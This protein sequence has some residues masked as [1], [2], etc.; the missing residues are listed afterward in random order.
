MIKNFFKIALR[1][2]WRNK[3]NTFVNILG[4]SVGIASCILISLHVMDEYSYDKFF[5]NSD[6][7]Y[8]VALNRIY[9]ENTISYA[10]IPHSYGPTIKEDFP[11]VEAQMRI[12]RFNNEL[13]FRYEENVFKENNFCFADSTFFDFFSIKL[14]IGDP[15]TVLADPTSIVMTES[16]AKRYFGSDDPLGKMITTPFGEIKVSGVCED[17]PENSHMD[18]DFLG[19]LFVNQFIRAVNYVSFSTHTYIK[20]AAGT[21]PTTVQ[22]KLPDLVKRY[23][24][25]QIES[26]MGV[27]FEEYTKA[28]N[29]YDYFLQPLTS[30]HLH[31]NLEA[32]MNP[33]GDYRYVIIFISIAIFILVLACINFINLSTAQAAE[34]AKEVGIRKVVGSNKKFLVRQFLFESIFVSFFSLW[35][36]LIL[37][38]LSL[39]I[40]NNLAQKSL[41]IDYFGNPY[42]LPSLFCVS[43]FVGI[44]AG[45]YP[46]FFLSSYKPVE[47]LKG[48]FGSS[49]RGRI[50]RYSLVIFQFTISIGLIAFTL[51]VNSQ[52]RYIMNKNL[53]FDKEKVVVVDRIFSLRENMQI[54]IDEVK[55]MPEVKNVSLSGSE[56]QGGFYF[57]VMLQKDAN[58]EILTTRG[59]IVDDFFVKTMGL[60]IADGRDFSDQF[61][62]SLKVLVNEAFVK[63]FDFKEPVGAR[64]RFRF[65]NED[66]FDEYTIVGVVKNYHYN[67]LH[68]P[69]QSFIMFNNEER[70]GAAGQLNVKL[71]KGNITS[72]I[73][74]IENKWNEFSNESLF[75]YYFLDEHLGQMYTMEKTSMR[76]FSIFSLLAII[77]AC[78]G[79]LGLASY[80]AIQRTKE[81]GIR[82]A[83]GA[84]VSNIILLL[85]YDFTKW[86]VFANIIAWPLAYLLMNNWLKNFAYRT[87]IGIWI[88]IVSGGLSI[89]IA[90]V[91]IIFMAYKAASRNP[92]NSLRYE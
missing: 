83:M 32:E 23:A 7:I 86:V 88:F 43:I 70:G 79:L 53:G 46:S 58:S 62:D 9:P 31:S 22:A 16:T 27:T 20:L 26:Q 37:I 81:V 6:N 91:T 36:G 87:N 67:S 60:E 19:S 35:I 61:D 8:R 77:I 63:E 68:Q 3:L 74:E 75:S 84:S 76:I 40:F 89:L 49:K 55:K 11:E 59:M 38:E 54:F 1:N 48:K 78:I 47:V 28:G 25:G 15:K 10:I 56:I 71:T 2:L 42:V 34:R 12:S 90:L 39:P 72:T 64:F 4:L 17:V 65:N 57:G 18:F 5:E 44:I 45:I 69:I 13:V 29:G 85:S 82:K 92:V 24:A 33:N 41:Y 51:L 21:N 50:L 52:I 14:L 30:I 66:P 80:M 73:Q